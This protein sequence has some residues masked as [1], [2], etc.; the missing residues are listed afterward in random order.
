MLS[1]RL[2]DIHSHLFIATAILKF[3]EKGQRSE[4]EQQHAQLALEKH[5]SKLRMH[6]MS[7]SQTFLCEPQLVQSNSSV[8]LLV[9]LSSNQVIS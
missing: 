3:Y 8:S 2:A 7:Y 1:G 6:L 5:L 4:A 9:V